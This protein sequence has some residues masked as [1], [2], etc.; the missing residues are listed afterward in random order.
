MQEKELAAIVNNMKDELIVLDENKGVTRLNPYMEQ[1]LGVRAA[2]VQNKSISE[3]KE[4]PRLRLLARF[5]QTESPDNEVVVTE[6]YERLLRLHSS[7]LKRGKGKDL[8]EVKVMLDVAQQRG[9]D[10][11]KLH[12]IANTAHELGT[13]LHFIRAFVKLILDM[14]CSGRILRRCLGVH[15]PLLALS[16]STYCSGPVRSGITAY[17]ISL[18]L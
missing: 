5:A 14:R 3:L 9:V 6:P 15:E 12:L 8:E 4:D 2:E 1:M 10:Q 11:M 16:M 7:I 18:I 13:P 17:R